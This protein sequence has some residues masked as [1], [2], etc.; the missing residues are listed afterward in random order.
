[1]IFMQSYGKGLAPSKRRPCRAHIKKERAVKDSLRKSDYTVR[2]IPA[3][4]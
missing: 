4:S 3:L 1:M 2:F